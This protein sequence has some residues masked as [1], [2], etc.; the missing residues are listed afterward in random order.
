MRTKLPNKIGWSERAAMLLRSG[1]RCKLGPAFYAR[2]YASGSG[3]GGNTSLLPCV[4]DFV[5]QGVR[6]AK[7][8]LNQLIIGGRTL[9][10]VVDVGQK[11]GY[12]ALSESV[13]SD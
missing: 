2:H 13:T 1:R 8:A 6:A 5:R 4:P 10:Q 7:V 12:V 11:P 9:G 3:F